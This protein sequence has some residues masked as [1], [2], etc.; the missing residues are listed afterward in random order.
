MARCRAAV[1]GLEFTL[2]LAKS[3]SSFIR[4]LIFFS[5]SAFLTGSSVLASCSRSFLISSSS[6]CR[7][8]VEPSCSSFVH[9]SSLSLLI[10]AELLPL[11]VV[12]EKLL[13]FFVAEFPPHVSQE[14]LL[15]DQLLEIVGFLAGLHA[16]EG[17]LEVLD[18]LLRFFGKGAFAVV[19]LQAGRCCV[20]GGLFA[21]FQLLLPVAVLPG[22]LD[23]A[24]RIELRNPQEAGD[25]ERRGQPARRSRLVR[26]KGNDA[27][28]EDFRRP[29]LP[30]PWRPAP[31][32][33]PPIFR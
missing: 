19:F 4:F 12:A 15:A 32:I 29:V 3:D 18:R 17:R 2:S 23:L 10:A 16:V 1:K 26:L 30:P 27:A 14:L 31:D 11:R 28:G 6:F 20:L 8:F 25:H 13:E 7:L 33:R 24:E 9:F 5:S 22:R 21:L